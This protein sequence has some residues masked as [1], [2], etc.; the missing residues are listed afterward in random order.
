MYLSHTVTAFMDK[1]DVDYDTVGHSHSFTSGQSASA[2]QLP[3]SRLAKAVLFC[4][5]DDYVLAVVPASAQVDRRALKEMM[6]H[7]NLELA[8][9]DE[10]ALMFPDCELGA[11]PPLG[12]AYG[13]ET[14]VDDSLLEQEEVYFEGGDH[15][16]L[17]HVTRDAFLRLMAGAPHGNISGI[18]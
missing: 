15:E 12:G 4:D 14:V 10:V 11:I 5:E 9:E 18:N 1:C 7:K 2:A 6:G 13:L 8:E 3:R 17:V 16:H